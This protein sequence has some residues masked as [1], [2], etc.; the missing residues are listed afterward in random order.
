MLQE[1]ELHSAHVPRHCSSQDQHVPGCTLHMLWGPGVWLCYC[2]C[3]RAWTCN[4]HML[5]GMDVGLHSAHSSEHGCALCI[6]NMDV[7]LHS[8]HAPELCTLHMLWG[9]DAWLYSTD[10]AG[11][12]CLTAH[13]TCSGAWTCTLHMLRVS[14]PVLQ[15][16]LQCPG[17]S[18]A[19]RGRAGPGDLREGL[20]RLLC[21]AWAGLVWLGGRG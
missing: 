5:W 8:S 20:G 11:H 3:S 10:A 18:G 13:Y 16:P 9:M 15:C 1:T 7:W 17:R 14:L 4:L 12:G 19:G 21:C 6:W 2:I